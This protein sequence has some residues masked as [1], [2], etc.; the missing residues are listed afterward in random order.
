M[1]KLCRLSP[2][3]RATLKLL[4]TSPQR[5]R[6]D[7]PASDRIPKSSSRSPHLT[8][9]R[10]R[11]A[12]SKTVSRRSGSASLQTLL[13]YR[14]PRHRA[15][16]PSDTSMPLATVPRSRGRSVSQASIAF[17]RDHSRSSANQHQESIAPSTLQETEPERKAGH[18]TQKRK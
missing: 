1:R 9:S 8:Q 18:S 6:K 3:R 5:I 15:T 10:D 2:A 11:M 12:C 17:L 14:V 13:S 16:P 4:A 7:V